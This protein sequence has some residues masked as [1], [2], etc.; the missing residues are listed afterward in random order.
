MEV[1][2]DVVLKSPYVGL[3]TYVHVAADNQFPASS[4]EEHRAVAH[5]VF[6]DRDGTTI[7]DLTVHQQ[8]SPLADPNAQYPRCHSADGVKRRLH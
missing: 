3:L 8:V 5:A 2:C 1:I 7:P 4:I 6:T